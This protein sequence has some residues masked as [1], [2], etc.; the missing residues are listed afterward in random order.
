MKSKTFNSRKLFISNFLKERVEF[1]HSEP[2]F[3][4]NDDT[5]YITNYFN[6]EVYTPDFITQKIKPFYYYLLSYY[7]KYYSPFSY[8][9]FS[10]KPH[11]NDY[12]DASIEFTQCQFYYPETSYSSETLEQF[13][14][15][16]SKIKND[17]FFT[18]PIYP[19]FFEIRIKT[20][21][22]YKREI[23]KS[24]KTDECVIC[25]SS[26]PNIINTNC[27]HISTCADCELKEEIT[28][29][30]ICRTNNTKEKFKIDF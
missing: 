28:I 22:L 4:D 7:E 17:G 23:Q 26:S 12:E 21:P 30:P 20:I 11:L 6:P 16:L 29:C 14:S 13:N 19:F 8:I 10:I 15:T 24:F 9:S 3:L 27:G 2:L 18:I 25:L 5:I 1:S